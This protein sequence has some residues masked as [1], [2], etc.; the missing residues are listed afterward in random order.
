V[1]LDSMRLPDLL[2]PITLNRCAV[3]SGLL[4]SRKE[5]SDEQGDKRHV[6]APRSMN[7]YLYLLRK[8]LK[9]AMLFTLTPVDHHNTIGLCGQYQAVAGS[10][11]NSRHVIYQMF[12]RS[13]LYRI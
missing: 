1:K 6:T 3:K 12:A 5:H 13:A 8:F 7:R 9:R 10:N 11:S 4:W 2:N